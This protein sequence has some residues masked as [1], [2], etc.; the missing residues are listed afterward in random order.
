MI[1]VTRKLVIWT[2]L[3]EAAVLES[4]RRKDLYVALI[5]AVL[6][7]GAAATIGTFGVSGLEIFLKD[8]ALTVV[9]LLSILM[10]IL[11]SSRQVAEEVSRRTV[12][13]LLARPIGR[14]DLLIGKFLGAFALSA[15]SLGLF[16]LVAWGALACYGLNVGAVLFIEYLVVR[17]VS[18]GL[19]CAM[20]IALSL[21]LTPSATVTVALLLAIGSTTFRDAI[22]LLYGPASAATQTLLRVSYFVLPHLDLFDLSKKVSYG[23][24]PVHAWVV[25]DL[26]LYAIVY[27]ALF[28]GIGWLRFR[29]QAL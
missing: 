10:A 2:A 21:F 17:L 23:W 16:G 19:I 29:R 5:L 9:N 7:I 8:T 13:P 11:F 22:M 15:I 27:C 12:Y 1:A 25:G 6:M 26:V 20:T 28:L 4:I 24:Q 18:L 14:G 3:A